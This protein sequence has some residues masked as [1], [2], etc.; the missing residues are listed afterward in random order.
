MSRDPEEV[1]RLTE[2]TYKVS[3]ERG[4]A[5]R[6]HLC[7]ATRGFSRGNAAN[8]YLF[9]P[10]YFFFY[11]YLFLLFTFFFFSFVF[12]PFP[13]PFPRSPFRS[14]AGSRPAAPPARGRDKAASRPVP[15]LQRARSDSQP[16]FPRSVL[17]IRWCGDPGGCGPLLE[18][19]LR[20]GHSLKMA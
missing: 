17:A 1:N 11:L 5:A 15:A 16:S 19:F 9:F 12:F 3:A 7:P 8:F 4:G 13:S 20:T 18:P 10:L 6:G 2:N 14:P